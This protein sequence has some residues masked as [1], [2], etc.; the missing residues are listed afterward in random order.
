MKI[1]IINGPNLNLLGTRDPAV[2]GSETLD[3]ILAEIKEAGKKKGVEVDFFQSNYEG[4]II[5][6]LHEARA[7]YDGIIINPGAF[8]HYS[9]AIPRGISGFG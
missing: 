2:Y 4:S 5:D 3:D 8:T 1:F 6:T 9:Y 7:N